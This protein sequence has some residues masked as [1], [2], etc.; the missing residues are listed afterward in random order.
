M[1][2]RTRHRLRLLI[3]P[4]VKEGFLWHLRAGRGAVHGLRGGPAIPFDL[5]VDHRSYLVLAELELGL[6]VV[7]NDNL[8]MLQSGL[9]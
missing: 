2:S 4:N 7:G 1:V 6:C 5:E 8:D 3:N 9:V